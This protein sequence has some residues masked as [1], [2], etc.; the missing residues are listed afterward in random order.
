MTRVLPPNRGRRYAAP[1]A[2]ALTAIVTA[3]AATQGYAA[4]TADSLLADPARLAAVQQGSKTNQPWATDALCYEA[5]EAIRRRFQGK[6]I[7][8]M[9]KH[10]DAFP[11]H[12]SERLHAPPKPISH[13]PPS[14]Q[15]HPHAGRAAS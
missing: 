15:S 9:P 3:A 4:E 8:C 10:V 5:A 1:L 12:T 13:R 6:G 2:V 14:S 11:A 7:A